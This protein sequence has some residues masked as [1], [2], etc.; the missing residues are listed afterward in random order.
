MVLEKKGRDLQG[1]GGEKWDRGGKPKGHRDQNEAFVEPVTSA[2][3][4]AS[5]LVLGAFASA[6][7]LAEIAI[8]SGHEAGASAFVG[9]AAGLREWV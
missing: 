4:P 3:D 6:F 1:G 7:A 2:H 9:A 5:A 8:A